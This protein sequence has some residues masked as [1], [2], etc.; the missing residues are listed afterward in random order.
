MLCVDRNQHKYTMKG[1]VV[2]KAVA[3]TLLYR[4]VLFMQL[5]L[6]P[7]GRLGFTL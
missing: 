6:L 4:Y 3:W 5:S 1:F 7:A 2:L